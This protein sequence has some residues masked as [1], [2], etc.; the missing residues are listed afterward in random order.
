MSGNP[1]Y[2]PLRVSQS[3]IRIL[4]IRPSADDPAPLQCALEYASLG[5]NPR[6][7]ALSY[8]WGDQRLKEPIHIFDSTIQ[9]TTNLAR[10]L[11]HLRQRQRVLRLWA[12]AV[13]TN[14]DDLDERSQQVLAMSAIYRSAEEVIAWLGYSPRSPGT[15]ASDVV[16][17]A[18]A[19]VKALSCSYK[20]RLVY[21]DAKRLSL[22]GRHAFK[23]LVDNEYWNRVWIIQE[24]AMA[25]DLTIIWNEHR[26]SHAKIAAAIAVLERLRDRKRQ[27]AG[28]DVIDRDRCHHV[29]QLCLFRNN[30]QNFA[31]VRLLRALEMSHRAR[32]TDPRD[33]VFAIL[34]GPTILPMPSY[35]LPRVEI[36]RQATLRLSRLTRSL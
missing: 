29:K 27:F 13:C 31:P 24:F 9:V 34:D 23:S 28:A 26:F 7:V 19:V 22:D 10:A 8:C 25:V 5:S 2:R 6:Y 16:T 33:K 17:A 18:K 12:D 4:V 1:V 30:Q 11:R 21:G 35:V 36:C 32:S 20:R 14:Q 15:A 3:E